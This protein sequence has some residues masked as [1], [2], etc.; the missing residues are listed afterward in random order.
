MCSREIADSLISINHRDG[1]E[2][3][4]KHLDNQS[5]IVTTDEIIK[6]LTNVNRTA[7]NLVAALRLHEPRLVQGNALATRI[8]SVACEAA[9]YQHMY[10][11]KAGEQS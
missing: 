1:R 10:G 9:E 2:Y 11:V 7:E 5:Q 6:Q 8:F 3:I 4:M